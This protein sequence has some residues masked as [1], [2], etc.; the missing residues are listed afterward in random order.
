[1]RSEHG[2]GVPEST[3]FSQ[4]LAALKR[5][6]SN[7][8]V[9]GRTD[10]G[11]HREVC[12]RLLGSDADD[13]YF[14]LSVVTSGSERCGWLPRGRAGVDRIVAV[15][16][17]A[18]LDRRTDAE[19]TTV[20]GTFLSTVANAVFEVADEFEAAREGAEAAQF[21]LCL[22]PLGPLFASHDPENIFRLLHMITARVRQLDGMGHVHLRVEHDSNHVNLLEPLFDAVVEV[23]AG[24]EE[25]EHRWYLRGSDTTS[26]WVTI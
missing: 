23:R 15:D 4:T 22:D 10:E 3:A 8:L 6:G 2:G 20:D 21:R 12:R 5:E 1:M 7:L 13:E 19:L 16:G 26:D 9:V 14:R 17:A 25:P 11:G 24:D 18:D